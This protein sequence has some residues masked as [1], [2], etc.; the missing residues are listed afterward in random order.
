MA[1]YEIRVHFETEDA[2]RVEQLTDEV[3]RLICPHPPHADHR[4]PNRWN[5][6]TI[7]LDEEDA[8]EL[9]GVLNDR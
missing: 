4:C 9:E 2:Q 7:E 1:L 3:E 5:I 6:M 8:A